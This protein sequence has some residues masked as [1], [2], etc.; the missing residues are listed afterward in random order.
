MKKQRPIISKLLLIIA[1][2]FIQLIQV[3][4]Q[5]KLKT[6]IVMHDR[7][8][9]VGEVIEHDDETITMLLDSGAT[10]S[11]PRHQIR[12][13]KAATD[14]LV[15]KNGKFHYAKGYFFS[16]SIGF[17]P[18]K[19]S[20]E[21]IGPTEHSELLFGWRFNKDISVA[22]GVGSELTSSSVGG[23]GVETLFSSY[24]LYGRYYL[25]DWRQR[26]Y[27]YGRIGYGAGPSQ[28]FESGRHTG[29]MQAQ[30]GGGFHFASRKKSK[31]NMSLGYHL[32][33]TNGNQLYLDVLGNEVDVAYNLLIQELVFKLTFEFR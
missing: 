14:K 30:I 1:F 16:I 20:G 21:N 13:V 6:M 19:E 17:N 8:T 11:I 9:Y 32:Q 10:I 25:A 3:D 27:A 22:V 23:F 18:F 26:P 15:H 4:A 28:N 7:S 24:F 33:K 2:I 31:F 29:G 12:D 5:V